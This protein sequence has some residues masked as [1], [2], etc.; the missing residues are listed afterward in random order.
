MRLP[1]EVWAMN[2]AKV[3]AKR[4]TCCRRSVGCVLVN[5]RGHILSTGVNGVASGLPHCNEPT[6]FNFVYGNG[7]DPSKP[8]TGQSTGK[9][10]IYGNACPGSKS[11][12]GTNLDGCY[13]IHAEQN[14]L[15]QCSNVYEVHTCYVTT[16]PCITC[17]KLLMNTGCK[18]IIYLDEYSQSQSQ[19]KDLWVSAGREWRHYIPGELDVGIL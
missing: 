5:K 8:T 19:S 6:G 7:I 12:S 4:S 13:A 18:E 1:L 2:L 15:L 14:A 17:T 11:P 3:T 16:S 10:L 9:V